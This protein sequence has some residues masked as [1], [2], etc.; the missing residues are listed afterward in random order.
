M[1]DSK[2]LGREKELRSF[3]SWVGVLKTAEAGAKQ[4]YGR[5]LRYL[6]LMQKLRFPIHAGVFAVILTHISPT[7][8]LCLLCIQGYH[9]GE[10]VRDCNVH[11]W[12][13][14]PSS[15]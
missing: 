15:V 6:V 7:T 13:D 8:L 9:H 5:H 1:C 14:S 10:N 11:V 4:V 3:P 12:R 2:C